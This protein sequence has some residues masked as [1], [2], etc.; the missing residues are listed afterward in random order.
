M[1]EKEQDLI[2]LIVTER[3]NM[4]MAGLHK[5]KQEKEALDKIFEA[6]QLINSLDEKESSLIKNYIEH[7]F[8]ASV[9]KEPYLYKQGFMDGI[10]VMRTINNL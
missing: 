1:D 8:E 3:I 5:E 10:R 7:I 2:D 4:L 6:E 9:K